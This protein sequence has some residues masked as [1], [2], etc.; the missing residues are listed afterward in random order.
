MTRQYWA[1]LALCL[2]L[3]A[4]AIFSVTQFG[5]ALTARGLFVSD[6]EP[7]PEAEKMLQDVVLKRY[8]ITEGL[9]KMVEADFY[10]QNDSVQNVKNIT[11]Y[12]EFY[13]ENGLYRD[14]Q[15][16]KL[17]ETIPAKQAVKISLVDKRFINTGSRTLNCSITDLQVV[18]KPVFTLD[19]H[20]GGGHGQAVD[21]G[22]SAHPAAEH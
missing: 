16:W 13:D 7:S 20:A 15:F 5:S 8:Q 14:R 1:N 10:I 2:V 19:R 22:G 18:T 3:G 9:E 21:P 6:P 4:L 17:A 11:V 12:C